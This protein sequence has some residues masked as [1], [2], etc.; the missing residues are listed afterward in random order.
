MSNQKL[1][2]NEINSSDVN[3]QKSEKQ[4]LPY[5]GKPF[6]KKT[7]IKN[8]DAI[9]E[10]GFLISVKSIWQNSIKNYKKIFWKTTLFGILIGIFQL[11]PLAIVAICNE[12]NIGSAGPNRYYRS[13]SGLNIFFVYYLSNLA[14]MPVYIKSL[15]GK[16]LKILDEERFL[17]IKLKYLKMVGLIS[18]VSVINLFLMVLLLS[19]IVDINGIIRYGD[20]GVI[21]IN[22]INL[23]IFGVLL[24]YFYVSYSF[25]IPLIIEYDYTIF[26]SMQISRKIVTRNFS[27]VLFNFIIYFLILFIPSIVFRFSPILTFLAVILIIPLG[28]LYFFNLYLVIFKKENEIIENKL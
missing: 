1:N 17:N 26:E 10:D 12:N 14:I 20:L 25:S 6:S 21:N 15:Y 19:S 18:I 4:F 27:S 22:F 9:I 5:G 13:M 11:I 7:G 23:I 24:I 2:E 16:I 3:G 28:L 8:F